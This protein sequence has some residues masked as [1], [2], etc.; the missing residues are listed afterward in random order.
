MV[1]DVVGYSRLMRE[2]NADTL[3]ALKANHEKVVKPTIAAHEGRIVKLMA[4]GVLAEFPSAVESVRCAIE[5][6]RRMTE[7][8]ADVPHDRGIEFRVG[9]DL[10]Q[11]ID[12]GDDLYGDGINIAK[13]LEVWA[14]PGG[15][16]VSGIV[17]VQVKNKIDVG[18]RDLGEKEVKNIVS[19]VH[20]FSALLDGEPTPAPEATK[21]RQWVS[22]AQFLGIFLLVLIIAT[23]GYVVCPW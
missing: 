23:S 3:D 19:P 8:N 6:Q 10:G 7:R 11:V 13:R 9:I 2:Y 12:E 20:V 14:E 22:V 16:C 5:I 1:A 17:H 18:F 15:I 4:D 21:Q